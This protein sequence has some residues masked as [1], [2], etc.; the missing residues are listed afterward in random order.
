MLPT[1]VTYTVRFRVPP[2]IDA[3]GLELL[4]VSTDAAGRYYASHPIDTAASLTGDTLALDLRS[5]MERYYSPERTAISYA[6]V[7]RSEGGFEYLTRGLLHWTAE[8]TP[9]PRRR[10]VN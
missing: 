8:R 7:R 5:H 9:T 4:A 6:L 1:R 10:P 2:G 3:S